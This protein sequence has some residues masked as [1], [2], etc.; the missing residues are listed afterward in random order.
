MEK[1][2]LKL[3]QI[4]LQLLP[5]NIAKTLKEDG[6][7]IQNTTV[8]KYLEYLVASF[9]FYKLYCFDFKGKNICNVRKTA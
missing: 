1:W 7:S 6:K 2:Q 4:Y 3:L 9:V 5:G 8:E